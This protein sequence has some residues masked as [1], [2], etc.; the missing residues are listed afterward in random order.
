MVVLPIVDRELRVAARRAGTYWMRCLAALV[1][2]GVFV[3]LLMNSRWLSP[4]QMGR[5]LLN[6][7]GVLTLGFS[8]L[9][10]I[11]LTS[12]CLSEE[13]REGTLG[14][15]F[16]TDLKSYDVVFGK[17][18][19]HSL[20]AFFGL[21]SVFPVLGLP[22]LMGGVTGPEFGRLL[23][24]FGTTLFFS[25]SIGMLV[26]AINHDAKQAI[27]SAFMLMLVTAGL[28]PALWWLIKLTLNI[29]EF[30]FLLLPS[31]AYAYIHAFDSR[32]RFI[33][34]PHDFWLSV[35]AIFFLSVGCMVAANIILPR[36][37][38][39]GD[40]SFVNRILFFRFFARNGS[41]KRRFQLGIHNP[42]YWLTARDPSPRRSATR[43]LFLLM[44]VWLISL[45]SSVVHTGSNEILFVICL[46]TTFAMHIIV[47]IMISVEATRRMSQDRQ[48]GAL[49]LLLVTPLPVKSILTGQ[50]DALIAH[51][52]G[53]LLILAS[54][55]LVLVATVFIFPKPLHMRGRDS[56]IFCEMFI[57]GLFMLLIDF[58]ALIWVG[59]W[60]GLN[61]TKHHR[62]VM[63]ALGQIMGLP[64]LCI[65][66]LI[67]L[68]RGI[69]GPASAAFLIGLWFTV[70]LAVAGATAQAARRNLEERFRSAVLTR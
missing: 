63:G 62:A 31:P 21:L 60:R 12:D 69:S 70:G 54:L 5:Q 15:L 67:F 8:M 51:F 17:L 52:R 65:F 36:S 42:I 64:W 16:L 35:G 38:K 18:A 39:Q 68:A 43:L 66:F 50:K 61:A 19:A 32:Y 20:H 4:A 3:V 10:G 25:L 44:P 27:I 26:S 46:I 41:K 45:V 40:T 59:M 6:A 57:G 28:L 49:E 33:N 48:S 30:D 14:L 29:P 11:F 56:A 34:G 23:L 1:M 7:L 2:L 37:W 53:P 24:V 47:K 22:L 13:K 9:A 55:N 58:R